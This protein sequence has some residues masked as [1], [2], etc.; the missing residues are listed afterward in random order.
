MLLFSP[1]YTGAEQQGGVRHKLLTANALAADVLEAQIICLI[2][3]TLVG[4]TTAVL[5]Q[6]HFNNYK[7]IFFSFLHLS[8]KPTEWEYEKINAN[9]SYQM[10][11]H[12]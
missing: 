10:L 2:E 1:C 5:A 6:E 12:L 11:F 9:F 3:K 4:Q 7:V 8:N